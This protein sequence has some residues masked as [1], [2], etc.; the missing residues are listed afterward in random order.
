MKNKLPHIESGS[1]FA[2]ELPNGKYALYHVLY[3]PDYEYFEG[4]PI[5]DHYLLI[6]FDAM[7]DKIPTQEKLLSLKLRLLHQQR[8]EFGGE[9]EYF[10]IS[11]KP[12]QHLHFVGMLPLTEEEKK[13]ITK[14]EFHEIYGAWRHRHDPVYDEWR[15]IN[16]K[17]NLI[18][19]SEE[20]SK[21]LREEWDKREK[22]ERLKRLNKID[23]KTLDFTSFIAKHMRRLKK[24]IS[25]EVDDKKQVKEI[26]RELEIIMNDLIKDLTSLKNP[27]TE[28][29]VAKIVKKL[30]QNINTLDEKYAF[31]DTDGRDYLYEFVE[32]S[33]YVF[34]YRGDVEKLIQDRTW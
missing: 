10:W 3:L 23:I 28:Q 2:S 7:L 21:K 27:I 11:E 25:I 34:G 15:W 16:D 17:E 31:L 13:A 12:P 18:K 19:E 14:K 32:E 30:V 5:D 6:A 9:V 20:Q 22:E 1:V 29:K 4:H 24:T 33:T 8:F 26:M